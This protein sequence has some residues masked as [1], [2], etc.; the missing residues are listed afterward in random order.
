MLKRTIKIGES[1]TITDENTGEVQDLVLNDVTPSY[2]VISNERRFPRYGYPIL[3]DGCYVPLELNF[4]S[5]TLAFDAPA[6]ILI[7]HNQ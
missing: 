6:H 1:V 3:G 2:V 5:A 4:K 7:K